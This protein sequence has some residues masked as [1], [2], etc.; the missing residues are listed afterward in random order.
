MHLATE[1]MGQFLQGAIRG[2]FAPLFDQHFDSGIDQIRRIVP[3]LHRLV[4]GCT[5][6]LSHL[7]G[8]SADPQ[9]GPNRRVVSVEGA[10]GNVGDRAGRGVQDRAQ[11]F[12]D[13]SG[14]LAG[15]REV[16]QALK[17]LEQH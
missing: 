6:R 2:Q 10:G 13:G 8:I 12:N 16:A 7:L 9:I 4:D 5:R 11:V 14:N 3:H 15:R 17:D 1:A